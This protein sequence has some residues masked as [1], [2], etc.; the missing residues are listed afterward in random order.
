MTYC[1]RPGIRCAG[2]VAEEVLMGG[3]SCEPNI[4]EDKSVNIDR[5]LMAAVALLLVGGIYATHVYTER[6][7]YDTG[8]YVGKAAFKAAFMQIQRC[9]DAGADSDRSGCDIKD[10]NKDSVIEGALASANIIPQ[11]RE[12]KPLQSGFRKGW[13]EAR[14]AV[15]NL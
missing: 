4:K 14:T 9:L 3:A 6:R 2:G 8:V 11:L 7:E 1:F 13:E 12:S 15:W 10:L 5:P